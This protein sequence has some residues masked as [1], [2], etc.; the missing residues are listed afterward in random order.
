MRTCLTACYIYIGVH[1]VASLFFLS[2][3]VATFISNSVVFMRSKEMLSLF[4]IV[5]LA[6]VSQCAVFTGGRAKPG[7]DSSCMISTVSW[8]WPDN[9][10]CSRN[11]SQT[12]ERTVSCPCPQLIKSSKNSVIEKQNNKVWICILCVLL[13]W[14]FL[15]SLDPTAVKV[16]NEFSLKIAP[17]AWH[18]E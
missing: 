4:T 11:A 7:P 1:V 2:A 3:D 17:G 6:C 5:C 12:G 16:S 14:T 15:K 8:A 18:L 13:D 9:L 10:L